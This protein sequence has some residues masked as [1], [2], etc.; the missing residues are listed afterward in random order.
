MVA[1]GADGPVRQLDDI[2]APVGVV[3]VPG[4]RIENPALAAIPRAFGGDGD[5]VVRDPLSE[6]ELRFRIIEAMPPLRSGLNIRRRGRQAFEMRDRDRL[7]ALRNREDLR[8]A[9]R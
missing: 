2:R 1:A 3:F 9:M 5:L 8:E 4:T 6:V 7:E